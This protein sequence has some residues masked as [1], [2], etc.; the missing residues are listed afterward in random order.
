[1]KC[2]HALRKII[3]EGEQ[4][5]EDATYFHPCPWCAINELKKYFTSANPI[6]VER[7]TILARDFWRIIGEEHNVTD[8]AT[9]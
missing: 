3:V 4:V 6:P 5:L 8:T 1:M 9:K 7:A 2:T